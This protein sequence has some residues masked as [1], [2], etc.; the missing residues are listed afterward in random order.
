ME[1]LLLLTF[2]VLK[3]F[4]FEQILSGWNPL[5]T[6]EHIRGSIVGCLAVQK[7][8][9]K[10]QTATLKPE[11]TNPEVEVNA[12]GT[13]KQSSRFHFLFSLQNK[14]IFPENNLNYLY[15]HLLSK[16]IHQEVEFNDGN[17]IH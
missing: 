3:S 8:D 5:E 4:T 10:K 6:T 12:A 9:I 17:Q 15:F 2:T 1:L 14:C 13:D 11:I 7:P 16:K